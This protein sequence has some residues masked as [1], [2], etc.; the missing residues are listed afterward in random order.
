[1]QIRAWEWDDGNLWKADS[2]GYTPRI[3]EEVAFGSPKFR[4]NRKRRAATHQMIGP[5]LN[6]RFWTF[7]VLEV[8]PGQWRTVTGWPSTR[9]EVG[10]YNSV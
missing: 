10:W 5:A 7:C 2:H 4:S 8:R 6:G 1:M 9:T 3:V